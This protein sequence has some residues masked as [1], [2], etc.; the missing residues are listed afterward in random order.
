MFSHAFRSQLMA[1]SVLRGFSTTTFREADFTH[2]VCMI[3]KPR[4]KAIAD[5]VHTRS[6]GEAR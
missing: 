4:E 3:P 6:L 1:K 2:A 5:E